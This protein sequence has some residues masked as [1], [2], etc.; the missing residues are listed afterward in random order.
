MKLA[1]RIEKIHVLQGCKSCLK[2]NSISLS[3]WILYHLA[4]FHARDV[5]LAVLFKCQHAATKTCDALI[6]RR[7]TSLYFE[8]VFLHL[9]EFCKDDGSIAFLENT[10]ESHPANLCSHF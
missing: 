10:E 9:L 7:G 3:S 6:S 2:S 4:R 8:G 5:L 1:L